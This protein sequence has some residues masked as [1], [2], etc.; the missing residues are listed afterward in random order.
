VNTL[1]QAFR[2]GLLLLRRFGT[3]RKTVTVTTSGINREGES[4]SYVYP[5]IADFN[6]IYAGMSIADFN[7]AFSGMTLADF[8]AAMS[9][10]VATDFT[11]QAFGNIAGARVFLFD[12]VFRI[13]TVTN[14]G[15][16]IT[17]T[18]EEDTTIADLNAVWAGATIADFNA[19]W[20]GAS[21]ADF[22]ATPLR[23]SI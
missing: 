19:E 9:A 7:A 13:R 20:A 8:D 10:L 11:N 2:L 12:S 18:A 6:A 14:S 17:Y 22:V 23:R 3:G 4:G 21:F 1:D 5:T 15:D 16:Q